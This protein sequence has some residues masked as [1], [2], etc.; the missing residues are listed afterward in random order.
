MAI[1]NRLS[2]DCYLKISVFLND[3]NVRVCVY[4]SK[5]AMYHK[6][7]SLIESSD[8]CQSP[9]CSAEGILRK[10]NE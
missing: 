4:V 5:S 3:L 8:I 1:V 6:V 9:N 7:T 2:S 10:F